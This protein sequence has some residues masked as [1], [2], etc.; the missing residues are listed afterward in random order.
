[1]KNLKMLRD[2]FMNLSPN[3]RVITMALLCLG[4]ACLLGCL[5]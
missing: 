4:L 5:L 3:A 2:S 1:M